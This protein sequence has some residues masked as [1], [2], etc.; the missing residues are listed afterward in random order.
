MR[1][2]FRYIS[3]AIIV[4]G[5]AS[6]AISAA[7]QEAKH[8]PPQEV[9]GSFINADATDTGTKL[10]VIQQELYLAEEETILSNFNLEYGMRDHI[11]RVLYGSGHELIPGYIFTP[12]NMTAGKK[13]PGILLLHGGFHEKLDWRFFAYID[14]A[15]ARGFVVLFPEY[16]GSRGYGENHYHNEYGVTDL[17]DVLAGADYLATLP[18]VDASRLGIIGHSR[19]G[20]LTMRAIEEAPQKFRAAVEIA[21]LVDFLSYMAYKPDSRRNEVATEKVFGGKLPSQNL[22]PY[23]EISPITHVDKIQ[24]PLLLLGTTLDDEVPF[25]LHGARMADAMKARGKS[26]EM[27]VYDKAPGGHVFLFGDTPEARDCLKRSM[28]FLADHLKP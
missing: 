6:T 25:S 17:E 13:Y 28:D 27:H 20:M 8:E 26:F 15:V 12:V 9:L 21:G 18:Y 24:T 23:L 5:A 7:A 16:R 3:L 10:E 11:R 14:A 19:G 22:Q 4:A 2:T 1:P